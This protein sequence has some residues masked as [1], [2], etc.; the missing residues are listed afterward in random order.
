MQHCDSLEINCGLA[1]TINFPRLT[2]AEVISYTDPQEQLIFPV[3]TEVVCR[4]TYIGSN[5][6]FG[7]RQLSNAALWAQRRAT[8]PHQVACLLGMLRAFVV[9]VV[10]HRHLSL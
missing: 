2:A 7:M 4:C 8:D 10:Q 5:S 3:F 6:I 9:D 1:L